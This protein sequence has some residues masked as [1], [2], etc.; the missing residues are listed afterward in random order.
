MQPGVYVLYGAKEKV[1]YVG[2]TY[3]LKGLRPRLMTHLRDSAWFKPKYGADLRT[4]GGFR[5]LVV[6]DPR[7]RFLLEAY[8]TGCLCPRYIGLGRARFPARSLRQSSVGE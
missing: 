1:V 2:Q 4:R 6:A 8:A 5:C 3:G 7:Q